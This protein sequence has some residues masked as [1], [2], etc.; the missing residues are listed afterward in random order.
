MVDQKEA[1][2]RF[3][4]YLI[5]GNRQEALGE[6]VD[7]IVTLES[8]VPGE[9]VETLNQIENASRIASNQKHLNSRNGS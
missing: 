6:F 9:R 3:R 7:C 1:L 8:P 4:E 5:Y 2:D